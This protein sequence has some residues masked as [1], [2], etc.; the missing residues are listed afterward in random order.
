M[1]MLR[2]V[3]IDE[4]PCINEHLFTVFHEELI[5]RVYTAYKHKLEALFISPVLPFYRTNSEQKNNLPVQVYMTVHFPPA[6]LRCYLHVSLQ[7]RPPPTPTQRPHCPRTALI[8]SMISQLMK[9][10]LT[11]AEPVPHGTLNTSL[12]LK[13][14]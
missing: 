13:G 9:L 2:C 7:R 14:L 1:C 6:L 12:P 11:E 5:T 8:P 10:L 4:V 3:G